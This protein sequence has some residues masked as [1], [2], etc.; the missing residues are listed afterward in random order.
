[1]PP[2]P[3]DEMPPAGTAGGTLPRSQKKTYY[4]DSDRAE[5]GPI[6]A[7]SGCHKTHKLLS[8]SLS[9]SL[10]ISLSLSM[11]VAYRL[12]IVCTTCVFKNI[13]N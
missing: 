11:A 9:R 4:K 8:L 3:G 7:T 10:S 2:N 12:Y 13:V 1:M 5:G 6:I